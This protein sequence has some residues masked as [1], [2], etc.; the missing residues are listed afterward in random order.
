MILTVFALAWTLVLFALGILIALR[1]LQVHANHAT[2]LAKVDLASYALGFTGT[3][4]LV[5]EILHAFAPELTSGDAFVGSMFDRVD[6][7]AYLV[8]PLSFGLGVARR[9][10]SVRTSKKVS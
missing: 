10:V 9:I 6:Y 3:L 8:V 5:P 4:T 2:A 7:L 1:Y